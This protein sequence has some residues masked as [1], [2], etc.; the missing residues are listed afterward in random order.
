MRFLGL[1]STAALLAVFATAVVTFMPEREDETALVGDAPASTP[2]TGDGKAKKAKG[3]KPKLTAAQRRDRR[4]AIGVLRDQ[5]YRPVSLADYKPTNVLRVLIGRGEAGQRAFFF[6]R[7]RYLGNDAADDSRRI[8]VARAGTRSVA[9]SY[10]LYRDGDKPC[11]PKGKARILF[12][13]SDGALTPQ[14]AIPPSTARRA[15]FA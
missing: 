13:L 10:K 3:R 4:A 1:L 6:A 2:A 7:A 8:S 9:L 14:T 5:G 11:C 12:R 15:P